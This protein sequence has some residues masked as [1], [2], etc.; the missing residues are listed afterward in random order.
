MT[1]MPEQSRLRMCRNCGRHTEWLPRSGCVVCSARARQREGR[2][3]RA[4]NAS[5]IYKAATVADCLLDEDRAIAERAA[6]LRRGEN[7][8]AERRKSPEELLLGPGDE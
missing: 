1:M 8:H 6:K 4:D 2:R 7:P 3:M 5:D